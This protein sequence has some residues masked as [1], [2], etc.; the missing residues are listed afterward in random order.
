MNREK[1]EEKLESV[2]WR[3]RE[4]G[5]HKA[6][7]RAA[8]VEV[9]KKNRQSFLKKVQIGLVN[10]YMR[11]KVILVV[12]IVLLVT[13]GGMFS[14]LYFRKNSS[15]LP[16]AKI[17]VPD[18]E[19][20]TLVTNAL[21]KIEEITG[22]SPEELKRLIEQKMK[23]G[24]EARE[25]PIASMHEKWSPEEK[26]ESFRL[27]YKNLDKELIEA[28][29]AQD[30][31]IVSSTEEIKSIMKSLPIV[32]QDR[33]WFN[34][35]QAFGYAGPSIGVQ[36]E[37]E[38]EP[39]FYHSFPQVLEHA[40]EFYKNQGYSSSTIEELLRPARKDEKVT[41]IERNDF[42][43]NMVNAF[44]FKPILPEVQKTIDESTST[45]RTTLIYFTDSRSSPTLLWFNGEGMPTQLMKGL[46]NNEQIKEIAE[47]NLK[48]QV[49]RISS[50]FY[51]VGLTPEEAEQEILYKHDDYDWQFV[52]IDWDKVTAAEKTFDFKDY[53]SADIVKRY[54]E[55]R[56][57]TAIIYIWMKDGQPILSVKRFPFKAG[58]L[59]KDLM[60][61]RRDI[62]SEYK[63]Q[64]KVTYPGKKET[65]QNLT[66]YRDAYSWDFSG[67]DWNET[68][69]VMKS[70]NIYDYNVSPDFH[71][72]GNDLGQVA[73]IVD[74]DK[75][76]I[77]FFMLNN[78]GPSF[79]LKGIKK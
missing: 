14:S 27:M 70:F 50:G 18:V 8:V 72:N 47:Q 23:E 28:R 68:N 56:S 42:G 31:R 62:F 67:D 74:N 61:L 12:M 11:K 65:L 71:P 39:D 77:I 63:K 45:L 43:G 33:Y 34:S 38:D 6:W 24:M 3:D 7:L 9:A 54:T 76:T 46:I 52:G 58:G 29:Q 73:R 1:L 55:K 37:S 2:V 20:Q 78:G 19:A 44:P 66:E 32:A 25:S 79:M 69:K 64:G 30:L 35:E 75:N 36:V 15:T 53:A 16:I 22:L 10:V 4:F 60:R 21:H 48:K 40:I 59:Q 13:A 41:F 57:T 5:R 26:R 17:F 49:E 51:S